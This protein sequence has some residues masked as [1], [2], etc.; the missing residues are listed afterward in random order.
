MAEKTIFCPHCNQKLRIA[1]QHL[2]MEVTCPT[3]KQTFT[4]TEISKQEVVSPS[5][6]SVLEDKNKQQMQQREMEINGIDTDNPYNAHKRLK[7]VKFFK[8]KTAN[9]ATLKLAVFF[10]VFS[11]FIFTLILKIFA[12]QDKIIVEIFNSIQSHDI[13]HLNNLNILPNYGKNTSQLVADPLTLY[14]PAINYKAKGDGPK[15]ECAVTGNDNTFLYSLEEITKIFTFED[16]LFI[17]QAYWDYT[18][19]KLFDESTETFFFCDITNIITQNSYEYMRIKR[20]ENITRGEVF[21]QY[22]KVIIGLSFILALLTVA[23]FYLGLFD[24]LDFSNFLKPDKHYEYLMIFVL[25]L[26]YNSFLISEFTY[27]IV[28]NKTTKVLVKKSE[29][30]SIAAKS[31]NSTGMTMLCDDWVEAKNGTRH[32]HTYGEKIIRA[33]RKMIE[34]KK[35]SANE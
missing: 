8:R 21:Y 11:L 1:E 32:I 20:N 15:F 30:F 27:W 12:T 6:F 5:S 24:L 35:V 18:T 19:G 28:K 29:T 7:L 16:Q 25:S 10:D 14:S 9:D 26:L 22:G 17:F 2:G 4:A 13:R 3:C 31:G 34:E 23:C 33:I